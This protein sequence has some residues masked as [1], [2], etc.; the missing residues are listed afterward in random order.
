MAI[1]RG[2]WKAVKA[3]GEQSWSLYNM[4]K[5]RVE[6]QNLVTEEPTLLADLQQQFDA[7]K[8]KVGMIEW[9]ELQEMRKR[10]SQ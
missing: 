2:D 8:T 1:R 9:D 3:Y 4:E 6:M 10:K 5:D 7:W